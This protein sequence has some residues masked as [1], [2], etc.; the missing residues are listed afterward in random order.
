MFNVSSSKPALSDATLPSSSYFSS[1]L[2]VEGNIRTAGV[3]NIH[4][5][6]NGNLTADKANISSEA[7]INGDVF[8]SEVTISGQIVGEITGDSV[9][10]ESTSEICG[11]VKYGKI[12]VK[13]GALI[14]AQIISIKKFD[15]P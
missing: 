2:I 8:A 4:G 15:M 11:V 9:F 1:D 7:R 10:V 14:E 13:V 5:I 6:V 12:A 3:L